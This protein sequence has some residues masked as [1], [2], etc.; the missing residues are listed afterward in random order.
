MA[1]LTDYDRNLLR[2]IERSV[3]S[4][5]WARVSF[6]CAPLMDKISNRFVEYIPVEHKANN[7]YV[8]Y[9]RLTETGITLLE[10]LV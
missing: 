7:D 2:L 3:D 5:G 6:A 8:G 1:K 10:W 4:S 9:V